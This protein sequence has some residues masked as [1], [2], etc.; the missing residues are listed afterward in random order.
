MDIRQAIRAWLR[1]PGMALVATLSLALAIGANTTAFSVVNALQLRPL[2][3]PDA[4]R[5]VDMHETSVTE[6]C[7]GCAVGTSWPRYLEWKA[8]ARAVAL[9]GA[10]TE[11]DFALTPDAGDAVRIAGSRASADLL[12][13]LGVPP[14]RGR[15]FDAA[16][17]TPGAPPVALLSHHLW[18]ARFSADSA[19]V[20]R[21]VRINGQ[22]H[23]VIGVMPPRFA[24]PEFASLWLPLVPPDSWPRDDRS[25]GVIGRLT[26]GIAIEQASA[27]LAVVGATDSAWSAAA[28]TLHEDLSSETVPVS[29]ALMATVGFVLLIACANVAGLMLV[30]GTT[31]R[32]EIAVRLAVG[33][34]RGR[35]IRQLLAESIVIALA[36]GVLGLWLAVS[37]TRA[38]VAAMGTRIPAWIVFAVDFRVALFCLAVS[39]LTGLAFGLVPALAASKPDVQRALKEGAGTS[40]GAQSRRLRH[41]FV[42]M[43]LALAM[44]LLI[45]AGLMVRAMTRLGPGDLAYDRRGLVRADLDLL[46]QRYQ[47]SGEVAAFSADVLERL[48]RLPEVHAAVSRWHFVAGFGSRDRSIQVEGREALPPG[49]SPR[50]AGVIS[51]GYLAAL[52]MRL[53]A[54]REFSASEARSGAALALVTEGMAARIWPREDAIGKR[55]RLG[56][57]DP[58]LEVVG[59]VADSAVNVY[60]PLGLMPGSTLTLHLRS[61][62]GIDALGPMVRSAVRGID[63]DQPVENLMSETQALAQRAS[64]ARF[65]AII[66]GSLAG[67]ALLLAAIG[68]YGVTA[69][70]VA[71]RTREIGIRM[72]LGASAACVKRM[73]LGNSLR[74]GLVALVLGVL[75][76]VAFSRLLQSVLFGTSPLDVRVY[77]VVAAL[78]LMVVV[79]A[80]WVPARRAADVEP[81]VA[82]RAD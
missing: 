28:T 6:L 27:E 17:E 57:D 70:T 34:S 35:I 47:R 69:F 4:G 82:M 62:A 68:I 2:P 77:L 53:R 5:L 30:R 71:T 15:L 73:V 42:V 25:L 32:R 52:G 40:A 29:I 7:G 60:L 20:G 26:P 10:Y 78:L 13:A 58:W 79:T 45:G 18:R 64:P 44:V 14:L 22:A 24:T 80:S 75:G 59:V 54:G 3:Y 19:I 36:G 46:A 16:D 11:E 50:F 39:V 33:A 43:Q 76:A 51:D 56:A 67:V 9:M 37:G 63:G 41:A 23:Q 55:L 8:S 61:V 49:A 38:A 1:T 66:M 81:T 74:L 21:L 65:M 31:R 72:A 48:R 12:A